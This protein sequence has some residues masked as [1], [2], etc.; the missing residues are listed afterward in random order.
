MEVE[1]D[2]CMCKVLMGDDEIAMLYVCLFML[3]C[4]V[5][6]WTNSYIVFPPYLLP[7]RRE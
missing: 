5:W 1:V 7:R 6:S 2:M 3:A 4:A